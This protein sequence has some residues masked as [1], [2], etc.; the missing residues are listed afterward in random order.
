MSRRREKDL[1]EAAITKVAEVPRSMIEEHDELKIMLG[2][3]LSY[4][5]DVIQY[6]MSELQITKDK[7]TAFETERA[8]TRQYDQ[9]QWNLGQ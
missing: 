8:P 2:A 6:L 9:G 3:K 1:R 4:A 5:R 7:V